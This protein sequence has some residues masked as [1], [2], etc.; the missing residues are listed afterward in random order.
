[1]YTC[2]LNSHIYP[3]HKSWNRPVTRREI[4]GPVRISWMTWSTFLT[5]LRSYMVKSMRSPLPLLVCVGSAHF[6]T[7]FFLVQCEWLYLQT[8]HIIVINE[9]TTLGLIVPIPQANNIFPLISKVLLRCPTLSHWTLPY[10]TWTV[11]G[12][13]DHLPVHHKHFKIVFGF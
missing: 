3:S 10:I 7:V 13:I 4:S 9:Q 2:R 1:M 6:C 8:S 12:Q 5:E 11:T